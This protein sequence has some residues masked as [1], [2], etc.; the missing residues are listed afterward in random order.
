MSA[1]NFAMDAEAACLLVYEK[2]LG[3]AIARA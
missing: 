2:A 1:L 3:D